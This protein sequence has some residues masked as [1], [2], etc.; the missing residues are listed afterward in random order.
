[1]EACMA[2]MA[3]NEMKEGRRKKM[4]LRAVRAMIA[5]ES[6]LLNDYNGCAGLHG[7]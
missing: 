3:Q 7:E 2:Q 1:M 5:L 4:R 6:L